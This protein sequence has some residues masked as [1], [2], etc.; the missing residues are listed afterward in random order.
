[1]YGYVGNNPVNGVDPLGLYE[2]I[3]SISAHSM[4]CISSAGNPDFNSSNYIAGQGVYANDATMTGIEMKGPLPAGTYEVGRQIPGTNKR[5][6]T[7]IPGTDLKGRP[8]GFETHGCPHKETC[9]NGCIAATSN[10]T[11]DG[12]NAAMRL[13]EGHNWI[14][15]VP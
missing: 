10:S 4:S 1:M 15:V 5:R 9:S 13:E 2:C 6:L 12:F 3:Y 14:H 8:G 11:R 7:P